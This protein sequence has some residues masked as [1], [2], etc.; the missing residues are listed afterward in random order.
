MRIDHKILRYN[1][2]KTAIKTLDS[3]KAISFLARESDD[4]SLAGGRHTQFEMKDLSDAL[5]SSIKTEVL[6]EMA[7]LRKD[8]SASSYALFVKYSGGEGDESL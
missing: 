4:Y 3:N 7:E 5:R 8:I 6:K 1:S 2:L